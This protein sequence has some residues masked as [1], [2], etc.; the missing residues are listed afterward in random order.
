MIEDEFGISY[1]P[2][3]VGRICRTVYGMSYAI[4]RPETPSRPE[5]AEEILAE[6]LVE[7]LSEESNAEAVDP[8]ETVLS[9]FR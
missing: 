8:G 1:H 7:A 3:H 5:H 4:P 6:R 9:F 2:G